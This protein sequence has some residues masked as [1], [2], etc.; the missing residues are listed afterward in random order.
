MTLNLEGVLHRDLVCTISDD[1]NQEPSLW[2]HLCIFK[3]FKHISVTF[4]FGPTVVLHNKNPKAFLT[5]SLKPLALD[6]RSHGTSLALVIGNFLLMENLLFMIMLSKWSAIFLS[7]IFTVSKSSRRPFYFVWKAVI[8]ERRVKRDQAKTV[9]NM[10]VKIFCRFYYKKHHPWPAL[11][12]TGF[13]NPIILESIRTSKWLEIGDDGWRREKLNQPIFK[14]DYR[15]RLLGRSIGPLHRQSSYPWR[16]ITQV[17]G[18]RSYLGQIQKSALLELMPPFPTED[19]I[20]QISRGNFLF[21]HSLRKPSW[22]YKIDSV[23]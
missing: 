1:L 5:T 17:K 2:K 3:Y 15:V 20:D 13:V 11:R 23:L 9:R 6:F 12:V 8:A 14:E 4:I 21:S 16:N 22:L 7:P 10:F 18:P 19:I